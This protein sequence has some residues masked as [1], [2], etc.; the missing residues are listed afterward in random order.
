MDEKRLLQD[1]E[2]DE[3]KRAKPYRD[4]V[5]KLTAGIGRNLDDVGLR[6]DEMQL[7]L[8]N[9]VAAAA[10]DLDRVMPWWRKMTD[11]RQNALLNMCFN[12]GIGRLS[13][14]AVT[15]GLLRKGEYEAASREVL[16][17]K[18]AVQVGDRAVRISQLFAKGEY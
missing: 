11:A 1:L 2:R 16:R 13:G 14:F 7:M 12:L 5:G 15:L 3:G 9:D 8:R 4:T 10:A 6:E 17:S 18:W